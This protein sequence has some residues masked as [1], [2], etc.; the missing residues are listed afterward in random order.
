MVGWFL[1]QAAVEKAAEE[2]RAKAERDR[3]M[4]MNVPDHPRMT[5]AAAL[6]VEVVRRRQALKHREEAREKKRAELR[7][8][9]LRNAGEDLKP[10]LEAFDKARETK[11]AKFDLNDGE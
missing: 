6:K 8:R 3:L 11:P 5:H 2:K 7:R 10:V 1:P 9:R 4:N